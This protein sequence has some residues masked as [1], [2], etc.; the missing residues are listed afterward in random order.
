[1]IEHLNKNDTFKDWQRKINL[2]V[3]S[4]E[5][6]GLDVDQIRE[7][8]QDFVSKGAFAYDS[9]RSAGLNAFIIGGSIRDG[10]Q[11]EKIADASVTLT[12]SSTNVACIFKRTG[13]P[14]YL[15]VYTLNNLPNEFVIPVAKFVCD[16]SSVTA[17]E[18]LRTQFNTASGSAG[19]ASGVLQFDKLI[20]RDVSIPATRNALSIGPEVAD[21][22]T[23]VVGE[24]STW[25][26]L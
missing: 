6:A 18:D 13:S 9:G 10:S 14:A 5:Q 11:V 8:V 15:T 4:V 22:V 24:S 17:Y 2:M 7:D 26:V 20:E 19:S 16:A 25:V 12:A 23:V 3:D 1:M 21:G